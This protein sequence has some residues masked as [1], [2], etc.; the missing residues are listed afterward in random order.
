LPSAVFAQAVSEE[1]V[2][3]QTVRFKIL[4]DRDFADL[5]RVLQ[6]RME[7]RLRQAGLKIVEP[8]STEREAS[9]I[10]SSGTLNSVN[11]TTFELSRWAKLPRAGASELLTLA[12]VWARDS[13]TFVRVDERAAVQ[14]KVEELVD[15]FLNEYLKANPKR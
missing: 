4:L 10:L 8:S 14:A 2:G 7:V 6:T 11:Q 13:L 12:V 15:M 3:L 1:L 9:I 5:E